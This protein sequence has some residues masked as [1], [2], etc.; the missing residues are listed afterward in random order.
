MSFFSDIKSL[1][2][3]SSGWAGASA[4]G[5]GATRIDGSD[6]FNITDDG[7]GEI[8][9]QLERTYHRDDSIYSQGDLTIYSNQITM[10]RD[11]ALVLE[12]AL[13]IDPESK[14]DP[15]KKKIH[16]HQLSSF[17]E[18]E[19][20]NRSNNIPIVELDGKGYESRVHTIGIG[21]RL[22]YEDKQL[23]QYARGNNRETTIKRNQC[24][25]RMRQYAE[26]IGFLGSS[27]RQVL[28]VMN[29]PMVPRL[30]SPFKFGSGTDARD[31][32]EF[33]YRASEH[34]YLA[35]QTTAQKP[36]AVIMGASAG[37]YMRGTNFSTTGDSR[38]MLLDRAMAGT[39]IDK[40]N[41][42]E[43]SYMDEGTGRES[44]MLFYQKKRECVT[45][46]YPIS[47][48]FLPMAPELGGWRDVQLCIARIGSVWLYYPEDCLLV[49][50]T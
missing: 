48:M 27:A 8:Q 3:E 15:W 36:N 34:Q 26:K 22:H 13:P 30:A 19:F 35:T 42:F 11:P 18:P 17:G 21:Y 20:L 9:Q 50:G 7:L 24:V 28:G 14:A 6:M 32:Q 40:N 25:A 10:E 43:S 46:I 1:E 38:D 45:W 44:G 41:I 39:S 12:K 31:I 23:E 49:T 29:N 5:S 4:F 2:S 16:L 33:F 37:S 47:Y